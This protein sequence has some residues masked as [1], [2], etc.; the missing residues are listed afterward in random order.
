MNERTIRLSWDENDELE[1]YSVSKGQWFA[2]N[3]QRIFTDEEGEWIEVKYDSSCSK[4]VNRWSANLRAHPSS[5]DP[6]RSSV[7]TLVESGQHVHC[8]LSAVRYV[9]AVAARWILPN[10]PTEFIF[11]AM[12]Y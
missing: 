12:C 10:D 9:H 6:H 5:W 3:I 7:C 2:G 4:Q 8:S 1:I 11:K